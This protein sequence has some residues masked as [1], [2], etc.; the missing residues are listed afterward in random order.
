LNFFSPFENLPP[1]HENQLTRALLVVLGLSPMAHAVWLRLVS[2]DRELQRL[3]LA[4]FDTQ[5]RAVRREPADADSEPADLISVFLAPENPLS[6]GG[7]V[8]ESDRNQV[9]D[10]IIDYGGEVLV[11]VENKIAEADDYQ[12]RN[13]N[14]TGAQVAIEEGKAARVVLWRDVLEAFM[15]LREQ[16]LVGGAEGGLIE[17]FLTYIEDHFSNL[18]PF[19]TLRLCDGILVRQHRRLRQVLGE[20]AMTEADS[21]P[22]GPYVVVTA[23]NVIGADAYLR[24]RDGRTVE[25]SFYPADTLTQA[26]AFYKSPAAVEGLRR[27]S[28]EEG[29][30]GVPNFHFGHFQ[31]GYCWTCNQTDLDR[32]LDIWIDRIDT[33]GMV[34]RADWA[35]YWKWL[36]DERIACDEDWPEFERH[37]L[38]TQRASASPR[39]G[40]WLSRRWSIRDAENLDAKG[41]LVGQVRDALDMALGALHEPPLGASVLPGGS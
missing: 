7:V 34:P 22:Y 19:R 21:S 16:R 31:R 2:P 25:L 18:G 28:T 5:R 26:R 41:A 24:V 37:F 30:Y 11:V 15:A 39:P 38:N 13:I 33:A 14:V 27:L 10:A 6:G 3:P 29:W 8:T 17:Q 32:Y 40:I 12:A 36:T 9:L 1:N 35:D 20:A 23:G 4:T